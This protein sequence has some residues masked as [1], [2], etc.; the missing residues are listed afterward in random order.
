METFTRE[1]LEA[2][3]AEA[4]A[5]VEEALRAAHEAATAAVARD[6][7][8]E[9]ETLRRE[10]GEQAGAMIAQRFDALQAELS[11]ATRA[12]VARILGAALSEEV[13]RGAVDQLA[14]AIDAALTDR[15]AVRLKIRGPQ[16]LFE[17]LRPRLGVHD[18]LIDFVEAPGLDLSVA[19][20][21]SIFETR[22]SDWS[23]ALAEALEGIRS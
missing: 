11:S 15:E 22:I 19:V 12:V 17:A 18:E 20:E 14:L 2:A 4:R 13:A 7:L 10:M 23:S 3:A 8:E 6:H 5:E 21:T 16:S 1:Q 9:V